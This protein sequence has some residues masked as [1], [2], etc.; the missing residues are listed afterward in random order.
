LPKTNFDSG[1]RPVPG[2]SSI[3]TFRR[4]CRYAGDARN[5]PVRGTGSDVCSYGSKRKMPF[6][7][8][9][10][11]RPSGPTAIP[12]GLSTAFT[13]RVFE[14]VAGAPFVPG[15]RRTSQIEPLSFSQA[16]ISART[17]S[18]LGSSAMPRE[19]VKPRAT[20]P[21][22]TPGGVFRCASLGNPSQVPSVV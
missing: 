4:G 16:D 2:R 17:R 20:R 6:G 8:P 14:Y 19:N 9:T 21:T 3:T 13:M 10:Y 1:W 15:M 22:Q 7:V 18:P 12:L 11:G 5:F